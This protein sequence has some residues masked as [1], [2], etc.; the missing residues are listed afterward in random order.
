[1][2]Q[3]GEKLP[4]LSSPESNVSTRERQV[5]VTMAS[6]HADAVGVD[7]FPDVHLIR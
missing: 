1:M 7:E 2:I 6:D 4:S 3:Q 5:W